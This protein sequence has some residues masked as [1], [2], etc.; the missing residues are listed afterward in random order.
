MPIVSDEDVADYPAHHP[1]MLRKIRKFVLEHPNL[2]L[3]A[4]ARSIEKEK[5]VK[6]ATLIYYLLGQWREE[7]F[8][9]GWLKNEVQIVRI[10]Q[11][12]AWSDKAIP[13][14][15]VRPKLAVKK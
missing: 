5:K 2:S 3:N 12:V 15:I 7:K 8:F 13:Y 14:L 9:G 10:K 4:L 1:E 11:K 6:R